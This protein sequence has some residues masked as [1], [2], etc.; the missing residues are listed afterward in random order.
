MSEKH[1]DIRMMAGLFVINNLSQNYQ[2]LGEAADTVDSIID[3]YVVK[4][5]NDLSGLITSIHYTDLKTFSSS[6]G[7]LRVVLNLAHKKSENFLPG[8]ELA[9]YLADRIS[10]FKLSTNSKA[11]ALKSREAYNHS[12]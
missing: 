2:V 8:V 3:N 7:H 6:S 5:L 9:L 11:K 1:S 4:R 12:K 10:S